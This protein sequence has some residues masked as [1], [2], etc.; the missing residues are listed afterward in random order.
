MLKSKVIVA[1]ADKFEEALNK[2]LETL[3]D[4][5]IADIKIESLSEKKCLA[6]IVYAV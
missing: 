6:M 2:E 4:A 1:E 3:K 5:K